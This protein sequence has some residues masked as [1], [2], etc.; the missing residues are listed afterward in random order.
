[1]ASIEKVLYVSSNALSNSSLFNIELHPALD[2]DLHTKAVFLSCL[3]MEFTNNTYNISFTLNNNILRYHDGT[4]WVDFV[5]PPGNYSI[6]ELND[7]L[8]NDD[9]MLARIMVTMNPT[10]RRVNVRFKYSGYKI[11]FTAS[12]LNEFLGFDAGI[13]PDIAQSSVANE[14]IA[15]ANVAKLNPV[16]V[17]FV[18]SSLSNRTST[19]NGLP[20]NIIDSVPIGNDKHIILAPINPIRVDCSTVIGTIVDNIQFWLSDQDNNILSLN[21]EVWTGSPPAN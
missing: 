21:G 15:A 19:Y 6:E 4:A 12:K 14:I 8:A 17:A 16:T 1:M 5:I 18:H 2:I 7:L 11:D 3:H 9:T 10:T 13:Y 20:S